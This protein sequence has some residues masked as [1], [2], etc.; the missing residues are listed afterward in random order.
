ML[1]AAFQIALNS[2]NFVAHKG[3]AIAEFVAA[4]IFRHRVKS[5]LKKI[6]E[7]QVASLDLTLDG[8]KNATEVEKTSDGST[9]SDLEVKLISEVAG[10]KPSKEV[11]ELES[12]AKRLKD[13][14]SKLTSSHQSKSE[15]LKM[16]LDKLN[17]LKSNA[18]YES[19]KAR[20]LS[21]ADSVA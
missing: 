14:K 9:K 13:K 7:F 2:A 6:K 19:I 15:S 10:K 20:Q 3:M 8:L 17:D 1:G 4:A 12:R 11:K 16:Q 21:P 18:Q 5:E